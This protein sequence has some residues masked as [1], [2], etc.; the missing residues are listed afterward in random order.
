[1][2]QNEIRKKGS[3]ES[4]SKAALLNFLRKNGGISSDTTLISELNVRGY[5]N[6]ADLVAVGR[7]SHCFEI[8]TAGD[9]LF[10]LDRQIDA[11]CSIFDYTSVVAASRHMN[12]VM[13]RVPQQIGLYE[14]FERSG[15]VTIKRVRSA[16]LTHTATTAAIVASLPLVNLRGALGPAFRN[17]AREECEIEAR[18]LPVKVV[19]ACFVAFLRE[20]FRVTS[21]LFHSYTANK[22]IIADDLPK[23]SAWESARNVTKSECS[24]ADTRDWDI[25]ASMSNSFGPVPDDLVNRGASPAT[26]PRWVHHPRQSGLADANDC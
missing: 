14:I 6:R 3:A 17:K 5:A 16:R 9:S 13:S 12:A 7:S 11:Y 24:G 18:L 20:R 26:P 8:K 23:L 4:A 22:T 19:K 15:R 21:A 1:M 2:P 10:R 25:F